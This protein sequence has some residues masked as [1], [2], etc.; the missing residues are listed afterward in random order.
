MPHYLFLC[1]DCRK[2]FTEILH[3]SE[4]GTTKVKCPQCGSEK[5]EQQVA[6]FAAVTS[7]KS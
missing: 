4:L 6:A 5:V 1:Q 2:E 7:K 3:I